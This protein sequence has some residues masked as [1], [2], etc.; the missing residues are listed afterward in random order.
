MKVCFSFVIYN[1]GASRLFFVVQ[2]LV[3]E[4]VDFE[5][6]DR[7][8]YHNK[9]SDTDSDYTQSSE[10]YCTVIGESGDSSTS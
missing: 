9:I 10:D 8:T 2:E 4:E 3:T 6:N 5:P 1:F 7:S